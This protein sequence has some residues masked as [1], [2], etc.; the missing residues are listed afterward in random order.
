[1]RRGV[2][3]AHLRLQFAVAGGVNVGEGRAGGDE[4]LGIGDAFGGAEDF[5]ELVALTADAAEEAEFLEDERPGNEREEEEDAED[6]AGD[7]AGLGE[8]VE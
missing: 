2:A 5:E 6:G 8:N 1:L 3:G 7:P 4:S